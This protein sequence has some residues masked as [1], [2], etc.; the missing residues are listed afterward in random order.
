MPRKKT[1]PHK[2]MARARASRHLAVNEDPDTPTE[3]DTPEPEDTLVTADEILEHREEE[4]SWDGGIYVPDSED[5]FVAL[6][7]A[8]SD[9]SDEESLME[10]EGD[11]L[12]QNL[13][14]LKSNGNTQV[15]ELN[16][17]TMYDQLYN[18]TITKKQWKSA[19]A[20][21][22]YSRTGYGSTCTQERHRKEV[23]DRAAF[24]EHAK[25]S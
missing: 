17:P 15:I 10:L 9:S 8:E 18:N 21:L 13:R 7:L 12:E 24:Q 2:N 19:E 20:G 23:R 11:E 22:G 16:K 5:D 14:E 4:N 3:N 1:Y 6:G 25:M